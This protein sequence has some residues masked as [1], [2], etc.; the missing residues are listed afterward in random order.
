MPFVEDKSEQAKASAMRAGLA[1]YERD[2]TFGLYCGPAL[3]D[4]EAH[5]IFRL[6]QMSGTRVVHI[7]AR[8]PSLA[9]G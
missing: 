9:A 3:Q 5:L 8:P 1:A 7:A 6:C 4:D 2:G